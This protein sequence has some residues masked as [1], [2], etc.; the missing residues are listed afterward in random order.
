MTNRTLVERIAFAAARV[1]DT[2]IMVQNDC[3]RLIHRVS[4]GFFVALAVAATGHAGAPARPR[5]TG[6]S[7]IGLGDTVTATPD[8]RIRGRVNV[9]IS[10][11][12]GLDEA[13]AL[14]VVRRNANAMRACYERGLRMNPSLQGRV[15]FQLTIAT[16]GRT[17]AADVVT[18]F[19]QPS[20]VQPCVSAVLRRIIFP[21]P[22]GPTATV[23]LQLQFMQ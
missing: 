22:D 7:D 5:S 11:A 9:A 15:I 18:S 20:D 3:A 8:Q 13:A 12:D 2:E 14:R 21:T 17:T 1:L 4:P 6:P 16:T 23:T 19:L 10:R